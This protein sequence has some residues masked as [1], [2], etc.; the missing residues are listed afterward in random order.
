MRIS[1][2]CFILV[3]VTGCAADG[4]FDPAAEDVG[5]PYLRGGLVPSANGR[6]GVTNDCAIA[7]GGSDLLTLEFYDGV[8]VHYDVGDGPITLSPHET[9]AAGVGLVARATGA[10]ETTVTITSSNFAPATRTLRAA[11]VHDVQVVP[12]TTYKRAS[13]APLAYANTAAG[14]TFVIALAGPGGEPLVDADLKV[15]TAGGSRLDWDRYALPAQVGSHEVTV[16]ASSFGTRPLVLDVID[17]IDRIDASVDGVP[18]V[19]TRVE[20]CFYAYAGER[21]VYAP[22]DI[23][24][25]PGTLTSLAGRNCRVVEPA[26]SGPYTITASVL[27]NT[28]ELVLEVP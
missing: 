1:T 24:Y 13:T 16:T 9:L 2:I 17:A 4:S 12:D 23:S 14:R 27:G 6:C 22:F 3:A 5:G 11:V 26:A 25:K 28:R 20:V 8:D 10:G 19:G 7:A 15:L 21:E 18:A